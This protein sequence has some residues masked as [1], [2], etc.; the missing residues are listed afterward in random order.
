M[1]TNAITKVK[2]WVNLT[3]KLKGN[4]MSENEINDSDEETYEKG[5]VYKFDG[6][7]FVELQT[8]DEVVKVPVSTEVMEVVVRLRKQIHDE[9]KRRSTDNRAR[10]PELDVVASCILMRGA[11]SKVEDLTDDV[12]QFYKNLYS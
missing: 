4:F 2:M 9:L 11:S 12:F 1:A 3:L 6:H 8:N 10:R 5:K 7:K